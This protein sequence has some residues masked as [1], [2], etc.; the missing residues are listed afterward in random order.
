MRYIALLGMVLLACGGG[1]AFA[2]D[3]GQA[4][5]HP[6]ALNQF[7]AELYQRISGG[8][9]NLL[10]SPLSVYTALEMIAQGA[11]GD[12]ATEMWKVLGVLKEE[13]SGVMAQLQK[14]DPNFELNVANAIWAQNGFA[15]LPQ[16]QAKLV[17]DFKSEYF[18]VDFMDP[19]AASA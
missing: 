15:V 8:K 19:A 11:R 18:N 10:C 17:N 5:G 3:T 12:T 16:F 4:P 7:G 13:P 2:D 9:G 14:S 6:E 1:K